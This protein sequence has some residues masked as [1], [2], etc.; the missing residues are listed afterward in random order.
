MPITEENAVAILIRGGN[1]ALSET[2]HF[3]PSK[4]FVQACI[5]D[6]P[7][8]VPAG[9]VCN[10][11]HVPEELDPDR[12]VV[13]EDE[14]GSFEVPCI[15][16][17][18]STVTGTHCF[19]GIR[20]A[21]PGREF[22]ITVNEHTGSTITMPP[23]PAITSPQPGSIVSLSAGGLVLSWGSLSS[24]HS[25]RWTVFPTCSEN[26]AATGEVEDS[27]SFVIP[28]TA[29]PGGVPVGGCP[30]T[31]FITTVNEGTADPAIKRAR[32]VGESNFGVDIVLV[33]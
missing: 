26:D 9:S 7:L 6:L 13:E 22:R 16:P 23:V 14:L 12:I 21:N 31:I 28:K 4:G 32:L 30:T 18:E 17:E 2:L 5:S 20:H 11:R 25:I 10:R 33:P 24:G 27:G 1:D 29:L 3:A 8:D 15:P 19:V